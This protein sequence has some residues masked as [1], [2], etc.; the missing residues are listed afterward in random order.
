MTRQ[1]ERK[2][3]HM[4]LPCPCGEGTPRNV[5]FRSC[6]R[7]TRLRSFSELLRRNVDVTAISK[8]D[9]IA[10]DLINEK[11]SSRVKA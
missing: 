6:L 4:R 1:R 11:P 10:P 5:S 7:G 2:N 3:V 8:R 9:G